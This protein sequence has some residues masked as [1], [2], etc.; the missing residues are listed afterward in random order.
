M[1][2]DLV[3]TR[4]ANLRAW[5]MKNGTPAGEKSYFSQLLNAASFGERAARRLEQ[6]YNM[7]SLYLDRPIEGE[8]GQPAAAAQ[9][10]ALH[11]PDAGTSSVLVRV[12]ARELKM[13]TWFR[14]SDERGKQTIESVAELVQKPAVPPAGS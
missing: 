10:R 6:T 7:G 14:E 12:D 4:R 13:L 8:G 11:A 9:D 5:V 3:K 1:E 2:S